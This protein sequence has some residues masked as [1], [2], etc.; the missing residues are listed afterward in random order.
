MS[1]DEGT[2]TWPRALAE[3]YVPDDHERPPLSCSTR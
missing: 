2:S 1:D 3:V